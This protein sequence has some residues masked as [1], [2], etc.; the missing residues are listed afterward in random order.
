MSRKQTFAIVAAGCLCGYVVFWAVA[1]DR[2][3]QLGRPRENVASQQ[4]H[5]I[6]TA[7]HYYNVSSGAYPASLN[8]LTVPVKGAAPLLDP[9]D[10][11]DPWGAAFRYNPTECNPQTGKPRIFTVS[12]QGVELSNW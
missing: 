1:R 2:L 10:L 12:P 5:R 8:L 6:D 3:F 4:I 9:D 7:V 11:Q